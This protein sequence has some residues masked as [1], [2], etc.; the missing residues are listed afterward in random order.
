M[1]TVREASG[2]RVAATRTFSADDQQAFAQ[3]S[4]DRNPMHVDETAARRTQAGGC[5][6]HGIHSVLWALDVLAAGGVRLAEAVSL[7]ADFTRFLPLDQ[8][9]EL[10][11]VAREPDR[12]RAELRAGRMRRVVIDVRFGSRE[13]TV[14]AWAP[15]GAAQVPDWPAEPDF[16]AM[17]AACG[18]LR[19]PPGA[20]DR[21]RALFP[22]ACAA[23]GVPRVVS[24]A[25]MSSLVGMV[26]PGLHSIFSDFALELSR[27]G[28]GAP[29]LGFEGRRIDDRFRLVTL[30]IWGP[31]LAGTLNA[32]ARFPPVAAPSLTRA[33]AL[34]RPDEFANR[35]ALI[36]G[37]SRGIGAATAKLIAAGG[38]TVALTYRSGREE[39][40]GIHE[41]IAGARGGDSCS[42][43]PFDAAA[44]PASQLA[45]VPGKF[46]HVYYFATS[47]IFV[48]GGAVFDRRLFDAFFDI[49]VAGF[50][51]V[52]A[53]LRDRAPE[54]GQ[55]VLYPSSVAVVE[56]P[57][58]MT[59]Y[60]MAKAAGEVLC[61]DLMRAHRGLVIT[62]PRLPRIMTDQT[63]TVPPVP[64]ADALEVMLPLLR[65]ERG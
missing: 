2:E 4:D 27:D 1:S 33:A 55:N 57:R 3:L 10:T 24:I 60:A 6:V 38:G 18:S 52:V 16:S 50:S 17:G 14:P 64:A 11:I 32:F 26:V 63:A 40:E 9:V 54:G 7:K 31:G 29:G 13:R 65:A 62:A 19:P 37:G 12:L 53:W 47:R 28:T 36:V 15:A 22:H 30:G 56:R 46:T 34:V 21:A 35:R 51:A 44:D 48:G 43:W 61:A 49:Y 41:E 5:A 58:D 45:P 59:E 42:I 8:V 25:L 20:E 23:L 39:A